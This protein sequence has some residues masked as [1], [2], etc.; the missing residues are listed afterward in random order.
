MPILYLDEGVK[1]EVV[2]LLVAPDLFVRT[3]RNER[4]LSANDPFQLV[5]AAE[6]GWIVVTCN[7]GDHHLL[8][9]A[10]LLWSHRWG[11]APKHAGILALDQGYPAPVMAAAIAMLLTIAPDLTNTM[12][13]WTAMDGAWREYYP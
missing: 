9:D 5:Y 8:H 2:D 13:D 1:H 10:W 11:V 12:F 3:A 4:R 7:R 6:Q